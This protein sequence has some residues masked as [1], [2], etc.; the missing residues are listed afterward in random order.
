MSE[1][2]ISVEH[3]PGKRFQT[4]VDGHLSVAE[5]ELSGDVMRMTHTAVP[6]ALEGRGIA[7][8]LVSAAF[9]HAKAN[10][11]KIEPLCAYV[12]GYMERHPETASLRA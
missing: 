4:R 5:Y 11:L 12:A 10:H 6:E 1:E 9:E 3:V 2:K 7:A 8:R